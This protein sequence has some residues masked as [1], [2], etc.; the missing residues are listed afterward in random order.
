MNLQ[1]YQCPCCSAYFK[2]FSISTQQK[3]KI[4]L[5]KDYIFYLITSRCES[6]HKNIRF[7]F[8]Q[9]MISWNK[10]Y[11]NYYDRY[12]INKSNKQNK[13]YLYLYHPTQNKYIVKK[14]FDKSKSDVDVVITTEYFSEL[15]DFKKQLCILPDKL[16]SFNRNTIFPNLLAQTMI[17]NE[18]KKY[19]SDNLMSI[20]NTFF[21]NFR[22][23]Y[24]IKDWINFIKIINEN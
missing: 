9:I 20:Y 24:K 12:V 22:C 13:K 16:Y 17:I 2:N 10:Q 21:N 7:L 15:I 8:N 14:M 3:F 6:C 5:D 1:E 23:L 18:A 11:E 4:T 19:N